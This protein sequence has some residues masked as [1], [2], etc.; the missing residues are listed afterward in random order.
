MASQEYVRSDKK[1]LLSSSFV[2]VRNKIK[3]QST[4][5]PIYVRNDTTLHTREVGKAKKP[6]KEKR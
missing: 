1:L 3:I 6:D 5:L 4:F 2:Y